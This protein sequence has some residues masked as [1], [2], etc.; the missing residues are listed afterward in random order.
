MGMQEKRP[1][2]LELTCELS[3]E[4]VQHRAQQLGA[5]VAEQDEINSRKKD[6]MQA[7]ADEQKEIAQ[8]MRVL[9]RAIRSRKEKRLVG[10]VIEFHTPTQ[11]TKR[12]TRLDTG[13]IVEERAMT[14]DECQDHLFSVAELEPE[15]AEQELPLEDAAAAA[16]AEA[17]AEDLPAAELVDATP[18]DAPA[19]VADPEQ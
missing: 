9:S 4:E 8:R 2:D 19:I 10:C 3:D 7:F 14:A 15:A 5:A 12:T 6:A 17:A 11:A 1:I 16:G 18:E 13:E